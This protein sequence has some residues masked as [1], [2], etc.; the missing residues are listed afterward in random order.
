[1]AKADKRRKVLRGAEMI[2]S[3]GPKR[4]LASLVLACTHL[5]A[6]AQGV[7]DKEILIGQSAAFSG[8][9][10]ELGNRMNTGIKAYF[11]HINSTGGVNGRKLTLVT[12]D[13]GYEAARAAENTK[14]LINNEKVFALLGYVGTPTTLAALPILTE[15]KVPLV[16]PFTGAQSLRD[17]FNRYVFHVRASYF[18][19]TEKIVEHLTTVGINRIGVFYQND[20]YGKAGL[21]GVER[22]LKKRGLQI[23]TAGTVERNSVDLSKAVR[24][25]DAKPEAIVQI[26]AYASCAAF[27]KKAKAEGYSGLFAN[28]SFV[29][30]SALNQALG[31]D[32]TGVMISQVV[33]FP[34]S[35]ATALVREYQKR[36]TDIGFVEYDFTSLEG[37]IAAKVL[38]EGIKRAGRGLTREGLVTA[39][40]SMNRVDLGGFEASFGPNDR[41][42]SKY[43]D[44]AII[45][46]NG[47]FRH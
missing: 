3:K 8:P 24:M 36:M 38:V 2:A 35:G 45:A 14:S 31:A 23:A 41:A 40:E 18:D 33:P 32:G 39:L 44:L 16:G 26:S 12:A 9:A 5:L 30:S 17:P 13:D 7:T 28:V 34:Y 19:E 21:E 6:S 25:L 42:A 29:G 20:A 1:M 43:V 10:A 47:K 15:A 4:L 11:D 46:G 27:I 37:Y 22:A